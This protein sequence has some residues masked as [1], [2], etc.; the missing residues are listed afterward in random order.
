MTQNANTTAPRTVAEMRARLAAQ[1]G[2]TAEAPAQSAAAPQLS[3][4]AQLALT[5]RGRH[6]A[7]EVFTYSNLRYTE[8]QQPIPT[9]AVIVSKRQGKQTPWDGIECVLADALRKAAKPLGIEFFDLAQ[10]VQ[11]HIPDAPERDAGLRGLQARYNEHQPSDTLLFSIKKGDRRYLFTEPA[12]VDYLLALQAEFASNP[13]TA[14]R[15]A[16]VDTF[17]EGLAN[18]LDRYNHRAVVS[19]DIRDQNLEPR[20]EADAAVA[21]AGV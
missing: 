17:V 21:G 15:A 9:E 2:T 8:D 10:A 16:Y 19:G 7:A 20:T 3:A 4:A 13:K 12:L 1:R 5:W 6:F 18:A 11:V 14:S